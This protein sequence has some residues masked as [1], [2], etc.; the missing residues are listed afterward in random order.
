MYNMVALLVTI[1]WRL[2]KETQ[3]S[4]LLKK[5]VDILTNHKLLEYK[6]LPIKE[7]EMLK[8]CIYDFLSDEI[9]MSKSEIS[10]IKTHTGI[11]FFYDNSE[12]VYIGKAG[13][14]EQSLAKRINQ[15]LTN[16]DS[17]TKRFKAKINSNPVKAKKTIE[18]FKIRYL[19]TK[20]EE[21]TKLE[22][23]C[24][25]LYRPKYND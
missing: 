15:Y 4:I 24:I 14:S 6:S 2:Q 16:S 10:N 18:T 5:K 17:G 11:Y 3:E 12:V 13:E 23:L 21:L 22:H 19:E 7:I 25:G 20:K 8:N 1:T 9:A